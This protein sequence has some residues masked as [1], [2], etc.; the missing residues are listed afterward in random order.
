MI[1]VSDTSP[2]I[3][4]AVIGQLNLLHRLYGT[5]VV[6]QA[7]YEEI[8]VEGVGQAGA[9][10]VKQ[11]SWVEVKQITNR[12]L[13]TSLEGDLD[14]GEAEAIVLAVELKADLLLIDERK[15]RAVANRLG[16][17]HIGLLGILIQAKHEG[18]ISTAGSVMDDLKSKAGF[19]IGQDLY[20]HI[21]QVVG[22]NK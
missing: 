14:I 2:I 21:L 5:V 9:V 19:W 10:E 18:M 15:G 20:D 6:P 4:L 12:P 22:E 3:N 11:A 13:V 17:N 16:V 8:V 7:V 1:V